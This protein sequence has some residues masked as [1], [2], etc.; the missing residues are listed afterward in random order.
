MTNSE[1]FSS[2]SNLSPRRAL[3]EGIHEQHSACST[4]EP[5][6]TRWSSLTPNASHGQDT[7]R[8]PDVSVDGSGPSYPGGLAEQ[9]VVGRAQ[10]GDVRSF[11]ML[12]LRY[13]RGIFRL[14]YRMLLDRGEAEDVVQDTMVLAWRRL[15]TLVDPAAF[16]GWLYQVA[17]RRC[18]S[19]LRTRARRQ[20]DPADHDSLESVDRPTPSEQTPDPASRA[21]DAAQH[22]GLEQALRD[23]NEEQRALWVLREMHEFSYEEIAGIVGLPVSTV[24]GRLARARQNLAKGMAAWK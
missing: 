20:T 12:V 7:S 11:E 3:E 10:D 19:L 4:G 21:V 1:P 24:R 9:T 8:V 5:S 22:R 13:E 16:R 2:P 18:L 6:R 14:A 15:P 17:T 23:L